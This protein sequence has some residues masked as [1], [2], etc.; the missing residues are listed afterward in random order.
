MLSLERAYQAS[1]RLITV[2]DDMIGAR[3][4]TTRARHRTPEQA[5]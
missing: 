3:H 1:S 2:I 4:A 5:R